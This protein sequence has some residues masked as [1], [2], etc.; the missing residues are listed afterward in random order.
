M[1]RRLLVVVLVLVGLSHAVTVEDKNVLVMDDDS[2]GLWSSFEASKPCLGLRALR[3]FE[4]SGNG[5]RWALAVAGNGHGDYEVLLM[6]VETD[7]HIFF[8]TNISKGVDRACKT[9]HDALEKHK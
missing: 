5:F 9:I 7:H 3:M 2:G 6:E 8:G 1:M 4:K